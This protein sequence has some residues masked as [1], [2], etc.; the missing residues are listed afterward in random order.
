MKAEIKTFSIDYFIMNVLVNN[1]NS[2]CE[3]RI[4]TDNET[5]CKLTWNIK[6]LLLKVNKYNNAR[7][8]CV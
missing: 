7:L 8:A 2:S 6:Y 5:S 3:A 1:Y 4:E